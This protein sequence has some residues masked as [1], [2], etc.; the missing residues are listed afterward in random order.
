M[1]MKFKTNQFIDIIEQNNSQTETHFNANEP[2]EATFDNTD[3][4]RITLM[5]PDNSIAF[6]ILK[7]NLTFE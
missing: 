5:F 1:K 2:F 4:S 3:N 6:N 7:T